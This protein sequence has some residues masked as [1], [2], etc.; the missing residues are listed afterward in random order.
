[1]V[2]FGWICLVALI[3]FGAFKVYKQ[4][5]KFGIVKSNGEGVGTIKPT[6][7]KNPNPTDVIN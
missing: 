6:E 3:I 4:L 7:E 2:T 1:M 5:M